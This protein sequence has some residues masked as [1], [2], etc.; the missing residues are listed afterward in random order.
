VP[1]STLV[2]SGHIE[3]DAHATSPSLR[4]AGRRVYLAVVLMLSSPP[5]CVGG[6]RCPIY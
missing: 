5:G 2:C 4:F 1:E 6:K 3:C